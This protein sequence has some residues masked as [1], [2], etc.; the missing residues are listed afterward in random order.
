MTFCKPSGMLI[1]LTKKCSLRCIHCFL[2]PEEKKN[3]V[4]FENKNLF[5]KILDDLVEEG[6]LFLTFTGGEPLLHPHIW[7]FFEEAQ[8]RRFAVSLKTNGTLIDSDTVE[9]LKKYRPLHIDVSIYSSAA[10]EHDRITSVPGSFSKSVRGISIL[11]EAGMKVRVSSP[12]TT[13]MPDLEKLYGL[14]ESFD[15]IWQPDPFIFKG[16]H[17]CNNYESLNLTDKELETFVRFMLSKNLYTMDDIY[18]PQRPSGLCAFG[19]K[20]I[21]LDSDAHWNLCALDKRKIAD[22]KETS[23]GKTMTLSA[24]LRKKIER[25]RACR[26]CDLLPYCQPCTALSRLEDDSYLAC[27][28]Q[29]KR[30]A[31]ILKKVHTELSGG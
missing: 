21:F 31:E 5:I 28:S 10:Q 23:A 29:R 3:N 12:L 11:R 22:A 26:N 2:T 25:N 19:E 7:N 4:F 17:N 6:V 20:G 9:K 1:E 30:F 16:N 18:C 8:K 13:P 14:A 27:S 15:A 24:E